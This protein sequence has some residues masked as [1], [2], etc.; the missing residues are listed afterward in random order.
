MGS[1]MTTDEIIAARGRKVLFLYPHSVLN[2]EL[3]VEILENEYEIYCIRD[4]EAAAR[5]AAAW[6]GS[7]IFVNIDEALKEL[8]WELWIRHLMETPETSSTRLGIMTYNP[9]PDL[10]RK[11]LMELMIPCGFIQLKLGMAEAKRIILKTLEANEAR[12]RRRYVR[13]RCLDKQK[14]T[15]NVSIRE[16]FHTGS[17]L[18]ISVAGMAFKFDVPV[19]INPNMQLTDVQLRMKGTLCRVSGRFVGAVREHPDRSLFMFDAPLPEEPRIK[20]H[21]FIFN[22]LQDELADFVKTNPG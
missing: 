22:A 8:Q 16:T 7:I 2:E 18:D 10:A 21:R 19:A 13:A 4:H 14:A 5:V 12:G 11:Y 6:S 17:I 3:L 15:F 20:I 9:N 1:A